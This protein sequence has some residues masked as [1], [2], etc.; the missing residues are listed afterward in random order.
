MQSVSKRL[1]KLFNL[2]G[3][4]IPF[5]WY[6]LLFIAAAW[7]GYRWLQ[8]KP[9]IPDSAYNDIFSLLIKV[10]F[11]FCCAL[12]I[13]SFV[14]VLVSYLYLLWQK[15]KGKINF[16]V[17]TVQQQQFSKQSIGIH[18]HPVLKPLLGFIKLRLMYDEKDFSAKFSLVERSS[19]R[20]IPTAID[21][22]YNWPLP[23]I[24]E[25]E[26]KY[27]LIY[28]ED[29][30]QFFS[31]TTMLKVSSN[32]YTQPADK[33]EKEIKI[34]PRKTEDTNTR[35]EE[36]KRVEGE[37]INYKNFE[38]NDDVRRIVWKIYAK[39]KELVVRIPEVLDPFASHIYLYASFFSSI[40]I[41]ESEVI[42]IPFL[43]Y[44]K[45][46]LWSVYRQLVQQGF[47]VRYVPDQT[48]A[49]KNLSDTEQ[50]VKYAISTSKWHTEKDLRSYVKTKEAA[51]VVVSS[52]SDVQ[53]V[54]ELMSSYGNEIIFVMVELSKSLKAQHIG[55]WVQ[56]L[57]VQQE[58]DDIA[59]YKTNWSLSLLR[60]KLLQNERQLKKVLEKY[61][62]SVLA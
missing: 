39:N 58:K 8:A 47:E 15:S 54:Q 32:F 53:Q 20:L 49:Q 59:M 34:S 17:D 21:G 11:W 16:T 51:M 43:N 26:I 10:G 60:P 35:I 19:K 25:Y 24:R 1:T 23:E 61:D 12:L 55:D 7:L 33:R 5:T 41:A 27:A 2:V 50:L 36:L 42:Q 30:F 45:T 38:T 48:I 37:L 62:K 29:F 13:F 40:N 6:F 14:T 4:F 28:L 9:K 18:L 31:L 3:F 57:F 22:I 44:Y 46:A 56:W 52:L